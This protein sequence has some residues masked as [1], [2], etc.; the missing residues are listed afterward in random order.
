VCDGTRDIPSDGGSAE[1]DPFYLF[2]ARGET[3]RAPDRPRALLVDDEPDMLDFLTRVLRPLYEVR[4]CK[5]AAEA[6][7][8]LAEEAFALV[9]S[10]QTM[11]GGT[12]L[13]VLARTRSEYPDLVRVLLSGHTEIPDVEAAVKSGCIDAWAFKPIDGA[14]LLRT[15]A[16]AAERRATRKT[17]Q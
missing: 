16:G 15:I 4:R 3:V 6:T 17:G 2:P 1:C 13:E 11:P 10:D 12:G 7:A 8:A 14:A 9:V 5:N